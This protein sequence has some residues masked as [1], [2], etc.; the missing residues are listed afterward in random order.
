MRKHLILFFLALFL[1]VSCKD[2]KTSGDVIEKDR[3]VRILSEVHIIDGT[4]SQH[5]AKDSLYKYGTNR[6]GL[7][8][9]KYGVDPA[10][11]NR[12]VKYYAERPEE[13]TELYDSVAVLL[14]I[15]SD[16]L[17]KIQA[18]K[19]QNELKQLQEKNNA[20]NKRRAD[21]IS[22]DSA[23]KAAQPI[24]LKIDSRIH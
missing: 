21:S 4:I 24:K 22:R 19:M 7:L 10:L 12:S 9:K 14:Q 13:M 15:T 17:D 8:F 6:Y 20:E 5:G 16:S 1:L 11:F 3:M 23:K 2:G 18:K